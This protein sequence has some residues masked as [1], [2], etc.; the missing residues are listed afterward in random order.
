MSFAGPIDAAGVPELIHVDVHEGGRGH[1]HLD[2][3][4]LIDGGEADPNPPEG[5][6]QNDRLVRVG[7]RHR[8]RRPR[9][10]RHP[11]RPRA[12]T[13][14]HTPKSRI[15]LSAKYR[16]FESSPSSTAEIVREFLRVRCAYL[17]RELAGSEQMFDTGGDGVQQPVLVMERTGSDPLGAPQDVTGAPRGARR[18]TPAVTARPGAA[19]ANRSRRPPT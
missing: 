1:T 4:Y 11:P 2:L 14:G 9:P 6:S 17:D 8:P 18:G 3:R 13:V 12:L 7:R 10:P 19:S 5:E 15:S 16:A